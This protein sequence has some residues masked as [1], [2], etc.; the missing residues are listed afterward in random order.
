MAIDSSLTDALRLSAGLSEPQPEAAGQ[1]LGTITLVAI[2]SLLGASPEETQHRVIA[3][4][5]LL[6]PERVIVPVG[7]DEGQRLVIEEATEHLI[8]NVERWADSYRAA[9]G[10][11]SNT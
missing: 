4:L 11:R 10:A 3:A 7:V 5:R 9:A 8:D 2:A 1:I 6:T